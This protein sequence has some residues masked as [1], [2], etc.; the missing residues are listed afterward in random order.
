MN[1]NFAPIVCFAYS[2]PN[3][4]KD[5][6]NSLEK[7]E[8]AENSEITFYVNGTNDST[9]LNDWNAVLDVID[10]DWK[11]KSKYVI[12]REKNIGA[13]KNIIY[14][15][16]EM[17]KK[18]DKLII[19][20]DDLILGPYFLNFLNTALNLYEHDKNIMHINGWA[21]PQLL[22]VRKTNTS[23]SKFMSPW[24]WATW[25]DRWKLML[26]NNNYSTNLISHLSIDERK[27]FNTY[28]K[29]N[30]EEM[31]ERDLQSVDNSWDC[32]W[33][34]A[35]YLNSGK[36]IFPQKTHVVNNGFDGTGLHCGNR[37]DNYPFDKNYNKK[38]TVK[39]Q[40]KTSKISN[41]YDLNLRIFY[42]KFN[43]KEYID[44]HKNKF[45]SFKNFK[46][47]LKNKIIK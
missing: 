35:I 7:N 31:I 11:F 25:S 3:H 5:M 6:L 4:L 1:N 14:G 41:I 40:R 2:R 47:F 42:T 24:G 29:V 18:Y 16:T 15:I 46:S 44:F 12:K 37:K 28:G 22:P 9:N 19:V 26:E 34:Q 8:Y 13:K 23:V 10:R 32:Y 21:H 20:E 43:F 30:W 45:N 17:L 39:F 33:Y 27:Q 36:T 38:R